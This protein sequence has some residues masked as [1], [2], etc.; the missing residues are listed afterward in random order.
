[1][2]KKL[3]NISVNPSN[4]CSG[5]KHISMSNALTKAGHGLTL[6]E[7][8]VIA[9]AVAKLDSRNIV[10]KGE[11]PISKITAAEY[12]E[13]FCVDLDTAYDQLQSAATN[14]YN[15][16]I[17][18]YEEAHKRKGK[19]LVKVKMR[20]V[21]Q[22]KYHEHEGWV[23]LHWWSALLPH[24]TGLKGHFTKYQLQ[25]ATALRSVYS[26][27]LLELLSRFQQTGWFECAIEDFA[28]AM[29]ATDKQRSDFAKIRTRIIDP[30]IKELQEKD[31]WCIQW[32]PI[33][34]GRKVKGLRFDFSRNS[35][36]EVA[37]VDTV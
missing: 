5:S 34:A 18:F 2:I 35:K 25:Q 37:L 11:V 27:K 8:R 24:L 20:W 22:V 28:A 26:W 3:A 12:A 30:A 10:P 32:R 33:K 7:K 1:M 16:S 9:C 13:T 14:L 36:K 6:S 23:E 15:R 29:D 31:G 4:L 19:S 21:G 17:T